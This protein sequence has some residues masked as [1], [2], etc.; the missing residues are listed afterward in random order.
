MTSEQWISYHEGGFT[1]YAMDLTE[2]DQA[3]W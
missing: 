2:N 3:G 1:P